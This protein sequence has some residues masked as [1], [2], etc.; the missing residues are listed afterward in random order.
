MPKKWLQ[1]ILPTAEKIKR[2][3]HI[4]HFGEFIHNPNFWHLNRY[5]VSTA[6]SIGIFIAFM[7]FPGHMILACIIAMMLRANLPLSISLVWVSNP[8]TIPAML[9][10]SYEVGALLLRIKPATFKVEM[11]FRWLYHELQHVAL[12]LLVGS[13]MLGM[14]FALI[15]NLTVRLWWRFHVVKAWKKRQKIRLAHMHQ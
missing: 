13:F 14:L 15:G 6:V 2:I 10:F 1:T 12:P 9:F 5:S 7:P 3:P 8:F 11:T 4:H